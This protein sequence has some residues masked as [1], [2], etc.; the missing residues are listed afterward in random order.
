MRRTKSVVVLLTCV[1]VV[2]AACA[3]RGVRT[4]SVDDLADRLREE[5][6]GC[7]EVQMRAT[8]PSWHERGDCTVS[9]RTVD[10]ITASD[11]RTQNANERAI[12][13]FTG[14]AVVGERWVVAVFAPDGS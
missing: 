8:S 1:A 4:D 3:G 11:D 12:R 10:I 7:E 6:L 14:T 9:G 2:L 5:G 13:K